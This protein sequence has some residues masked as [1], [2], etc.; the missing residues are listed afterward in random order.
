M[1]SLR[2]TVDMVDTTVDTVDT[3]IVDTDTATDTARGLLML[4]PKLRPLPHPKLMLKLH[5]G[6]DTTVDTMA[7]D[8]DMVD[9]VD[10]DT[11]TD[12]ARGLLRL[13]PKLTP[14]PHPKLM[15]KLHHGVDT[16]V[17]TM[18]VD[19]VMVDTV[20]THTA[21]DTARG[22]LMLNPKLRLR[23]HHG[24]DTTVVDTTVVDTD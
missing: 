12:T 2:P 10:T 8:T 13:N 3:D 4:N 16:T 6:V 17:D 23:L 5:H 14:M 22:L 20:D 18:A 11:A 7:V 21:T 15:L 24:A 19:T 1:G 9:T